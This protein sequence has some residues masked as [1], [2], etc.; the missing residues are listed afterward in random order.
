MTDIVSAR[1]GPLASRDDGL[2]E[3]VRRP[4]VVERVLSM[5]ADIRHLP[6]VPADLGAEDDFLRVLE[7]DSIDAVELTVQLDAVFA[8]GF[9]EDP[10]DVDHL[11]SFGSL[12]DL[13]ITRGRFGALP[14]DGSTP[15]E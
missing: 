7:M 3:A 2:I 10:D 12:I 5:L 4:A 8:L 11:A 9:G 14:D 6:V 13:V 1:G 15:D